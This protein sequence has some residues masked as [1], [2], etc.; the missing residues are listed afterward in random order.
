MPSINRNIFAKAIMFKRS[1]E[2]V[3][4][5]A[6]RIET[7]IRKVIDNSPTLAGRHVPAINKIKKGSIC[8][9]INKTNFL[10][11]DGVIFEICSYHPGHIPDAMSPDLN[12][13]EAIIN[14]VEL[15]GDD[16]KS[17]EIVCVYRCLAL[18]EI[19][20]IE[21][22]RGSGGSTG[23]CDL[24]THLF[25]QHID[26]KHPALELA[27]I[28]SSSLE[29]LITDRGGIKKV[30]ARI[31]QSTATDGSKYGSL[32]SNIKNKLPGA[33]K[34]LI[35]WEADENSIDTAN[36]I[37]MLKESDED[38]LAG[39]TLYFRDGGKISDLNKYRERKSVSIQL[40]NDGKPATTEI[41]A[42]LKDYLKELRDPRKSGPVNTD[43]TLKNAKLI[44]E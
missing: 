41:E 4:W 39:V 35:N 32:L 31:S 5:V 27:D 15:T 20:I 17:R 9:F 7:A 6:P 42:A 18:G 23:L 3:N 36:A 37:E 8:L 1:K 24:L 30:T 28:G 34:C 11:N 21:S 13:S 33:L 43:G 14:A 16:G 12:K 26:P 44:G 29:K 25:R 22:V 10:G 38:T 2:Q 19:L 40:T